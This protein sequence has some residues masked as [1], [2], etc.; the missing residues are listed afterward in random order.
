MSLT[1]FPDGLSSFGVPILGGMFPFT[2]KYIF[3]KP[4]S[5]L[6]GNDGLSPNSSV[7]TLTKALA[8]A[9]TNKNDVVFLIQESNTAASTTDYQSTT[10][11]WNKDG[12]HL[13]GINPG[14]MI[15][16]RSRVALISS[17]VTASNLITWS[18]NNCLVS[19]IEFFAGVADA[20]PTGC[21]KLTGDRNR[22]TNCQISGIGND[23]MD[24]AGAYSLWMYGAHENLFESCYIGLDTIGR[25][26]AA[27]A[28]ILLT[29]P[30]NAG[31]ARNIFRKCIISGWCQSAGNYLFVSANAAGA[32]GRFLLF[33][34]CVMHNPAAACA[35]GAQMTQA[36]QIHA[37]ANG[38]V[39]LHNTT[40]IGADNVNASD[41]GLV[42]CGA[43]SF[44]N[45][46]EATDLGL[47]VVTTNA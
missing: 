39:I 29:A 14:P 30:D 43:G 17:Y 40:I 19:N 24:I 20:N 47:A 13:I 7:K 8:L 38:H 27:N 9:T 11:D 34:D 33:D 23:L 16:Q 25:G 36:M 6:D 32:I 15:G 41:T 5:G 37:A 31:N 26:S 4:Y 42:L 45:N 46:T 10:L 22:F 44:A 1:N 28:E 35:G 3:V 12:V 18:A 21:M 2:G